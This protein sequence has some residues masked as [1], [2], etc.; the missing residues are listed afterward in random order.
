[1]VKCTEFCDFAR[2]ENVN[3]LDNTT[4]IPKDKLEKLFKRNNIINNYIIYI[5][6]LYK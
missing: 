1:M 5:N 3:T 2:Q 4:Y 6:I